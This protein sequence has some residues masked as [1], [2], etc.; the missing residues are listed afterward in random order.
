MSLNQINTVQIMHVIC[1]VCCSKIRETS[2]FLLAIV[3]LCYSCYG[4]CIKHTQYIMKWVSLCAHSPYLYFNINIC[5]GYVKY[6]G[7][8]INKWTFAGI[9]KTFDLRSMK[10]S[11]KK[12][13]I[14]MSNLNKFYLITVNSL[15]FVFA[16]ATSTL[17]WWG[18]VKYWFTDQSI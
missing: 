7:R 10:H 6:E 2:I 14:V 11:Q 9:S 16:M 17:V 3:S 4:E 15:C 1:G 12:P 5:S 13:K 18:I 8:S